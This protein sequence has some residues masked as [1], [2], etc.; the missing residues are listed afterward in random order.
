MIRGLISTALRQPTVVIALTCLLIFYGYWSIQNMPFDV[1]P[2][3]APPLVEIQTEAPGLS[4]EE[5][6]ALI[7]V[8]LE[9]A[10][11]GIPW[12][13]ILRSKSVQGLSSVTLILEEGTDL[14]RARQL[15][16]ERLAVEAT[17]LPA[18]ASQPVILS[19]LS[20]TS[21]VLKVGLSS[22]TMSQMDMTELAKWT[23]RPR[24]MAVSGVAN[25]AIWGQRDKQYQVLVDPERLRANGITLDQVIKAAGDAAVVTSGGFIDTPNQRMSV[26]HVSTILTPEDLARTVVDFRDN[27]PIRLGDIAEVQIGFPPPIGD[28]II[29]HGPGLLL[30]VE[31]QPWGNTLTVTRG[32]E[33]A[34]EA[35][36]LALTGIEIDSTIFR[37]ATFIERALAN[38]QHTMIVGCILVLCVLMLFLYN[39]RTA[40]ISAT[41]I[42]VSLVGA[43]ILLKFMEIPMNT[44]VL[45]GLVIALGAVVD[46]GIICVENVVRRLRENKK[47]DAPRS[48]FRV[49]L[50]AVFEVRN[51]VIYASLIVMLVFLPV[52]FL[53]GLAGAFFKPLAQAYIL[54]IFVSMFIAITLTPALCIILLPGH[55]DRQEEAPFV[56]FLKGLYRPILPVIMRKPKSVIACMIASLIVP[57]SLVPMMGEEF[58]PAFKE[59]DFLMHFVGKPGTSLEAMQRISQRAAEELL[60]I[61]GVRNFGTHAG[62]AEVADEVVGPN[63]VELWISLD[64]SVDY[65]VTLA[66]VEAAIDG[67]PGLFRD[68]LT[69]L[70]ERIKEVLSGVS[71]SIVVRIYGPDL[72]KLRSKALEVERVMSEIP[73]IANLR[74]EQQELVPQI[75]VHFRADAAEQFGLTPGQIRTTTTAF[76]QGIVVGEVYHDQ[77]VFEVAVLGTSNMRVDLTTLKELLIDTPS[78]ARVPLGDVAD[79]QIL[80]TPNSIVREGASRRIDVVCD[81]D[82]STDLGTVAKEVERR[83]S[84]MTFE[85]GYH[86]EFLGEY[87]AQQA[88][89]TQ[90]ILV[91]LIAFVAICVF[92]NTMFQSRRLIALILLSLPF[93]IFGG[94]IGTW[95]SGGILSLGSIIGFITVI[96]VSLR[97][98]IMLISHFRHLE[99]AEGMTFGPALIQRG[100]EERIPPI[101]MTVSTVTLALLPI[102]YY[103]NIPGHEIEYPMACVIVGGLY[104]SAI[105][106]LLFVPTLYGL[107]GKAIQARHLT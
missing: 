8:P 83:V 68:V 39:W 46:D 56:T 45:A 89:R 104:S 31:K 51:A 105:M 3:F 43:V 62:R 87:A 27:A 54:A 97:H 1:F 49:I 92:L 102:I 67:Y 38:L 63:F 78:G 55:V 101:A 86:P 26:R 106:N 69:Y 32:I 99:Y 61:E 47:S 85:Q 91:G 59:T 100:A 52:F 6:E 94:I 80:P 10:L 22:E 73:G 14:I 65:D 13:Q 16:Q 30:I 103:G 57:C 66:E 33:E 44:M 5:V 90:L 4:A 58:M 19:P 72:S 53:E 24:L 9:N 81:I 35:L 74:V 29:N 7:S 107:F 70:T 84:A 79:V 20:S 37:P 71:S 77:K 21:R 93:A 50:A 75:E 60:A 12:L 96:G 17:R 41:A 18:V 36:R 98:G 34:I 95:F 42:P 2:E 25:V 15:V 40:L 48:T 88:S 64:D 28:A 76:L 11:N 23:V 82:G